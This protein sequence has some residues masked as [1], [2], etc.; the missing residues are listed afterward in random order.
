M[1][2]RVPGVSKILGGNDYQLPFADDMGRPSR[3]KSRARSELES[4]E[5]QLEPKPVPLTHVFSIPPFPGVPWPQLSLSCTMGKIPPFL[6]EIEGFNLVKRKQ[7][8]L[9]AQGGLANHGEGTKNNIIPET[10]PVWVSS[11]SGCYEL[12]PRSTG[13]MII[14]Q[15]R[16]KL[17]TGWG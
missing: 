13:R 10:R 11:S 4:R 17:M 14:V 7:C 5:L 15:L 2:V 3:V 9:C 8:F 1:F 12:V 16:S 6:W